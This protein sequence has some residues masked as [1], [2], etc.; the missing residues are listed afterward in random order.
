[1]TNANHH[2]V[3]SNNQAS[4]R[5]S[6]SSASTGAAV[7]ATNQ[8]DVWILLVTFRRWWASALPAGAVLAG[9][10]LFGVLRSFTPTFQATSLL[11][12]NEDYV[13]FKGVMPVVTDLARTEKPLF[14]NPIVLDP[15]LA[16]SSLRR[17]PSLLDPDKAELNLKRNLTISSGGTPSRLVVSYEDS[18][19]EAAAMICNAVVDSYLR[20]RDAFDSTRVNNLE[21]WLEPEIQR[22]EQEVTDRQGN[23]QKLSKQ[24]LGY[25]SGQTTS[26]LENTSAMTLVTS[27][28]AQI[29]DLTVE[30]SVRDA[31]LAM[32]DNISTKGAAQP[33]ETVQSLET[34]QVG[35]GLPPSI[36]FQPREPNDSE[37]DQLVDQDP[38]V[39]EAKMRIGRYQ[40]ILLDLEDNDLVRIR[41]DFYNENQAKVAE[42]EQKL[43]AAKRA[44]RQPAIE[45]LNRLAT[46]DFAIRK[47][48]AEAKRIIAQREQELNGRQAELQQQA[49]AEQGRINQTLSRNQLETKLSV[50]RKQYD[51]EVARLEQ[52]GG[53]T[54][55]LQFAQEELEVA[56]DVLKKLRD[57]VAAIRTERRQDGAVRMLASATPPRTP[58]AELPLKKMGMAGGAAMMVPFFFGLLWE[59]RMRRITDS[60]MCGGL[61]L[62]GEI[63]RMP[64]GTRSTKDRRIFQ[65]SVDTLRSNLFHSTRWKGT[66]SI[67]VVSSVSSE[68]KSSVASQLSLSIAKATGET[69]LL[70]DADLR[71]P[72]QHR[73]FGVEMGP[74]LSAVLAGTTPFLDAVNTSLGHLVHLLPAGELTASP[75]RL[76]SPQRLQAFMK[77]ALNNYTYVVIDTAP[78]LAAGETLAIAATVESTLLCLMRD[79]SRLDSIR[80]TTRRLEAAGAAIVGTVFSGVTS[81]QYAF[82]YGDYHYSLSDGGFS[83]VGMRDRQEP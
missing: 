43:E 83:D 65:E 47:A 57:R 55:E 44:A 75:H 72:D 41:R 7:V 51:E 35:E 68:G 61:S 62:V 20:Q 49:N 3:H 10:A 53:T 59:L 24:T 81:R 74:G 56:N 6:H 80:Q 60:S 18:D 78:V 5:A 58:V 38:Q 19:R 30:L 66:R 27:L 39:R 28:R 29:A 36:Q 25:A 33:S 12:A 31:Q 50:L 46:E 77:D 40:S 2:S 32:Q 22:W 16:D 15:V 14:F 76:M 1:M 8:F 34:D 69:V 37:I 63:A 9:I 52:F 23:V 17:A 64:A 73:L 11:E 79:V 67:A 70:V 82:R 13:V 71:R 26:M 42:W 54:A 4:T 21:R 48:E 45:K